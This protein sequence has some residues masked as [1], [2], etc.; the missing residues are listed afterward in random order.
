[1]ADYGATAGLPVD[2]PAFVGQVRDWLDGIAQATDEAFPD[3]KLVRIENDEP[4]ITRPPKRP[5][6]AG[7]RD[8]EARLA[9]H[10]PEENI[11]DMLTDTEHW[12]HWTSPIGPISGH[13]TKLE[14]AVVRYLATV[15]CYG[16]NMGPSQAARSLARLDRRQIERINQHHVIEDGLDQ[17]D[18]IVINAYNRFVLP[19]AWGSGKHA[20]ADGTKWDLYER[21][22]LAEYHIRYGEFGGIGYYHLSDLYIALISHFIPCGAYEGV[23]ILDPF[24]QNKSDIQPDTVHADTHG[25]SAPIFGLAYTL[26]IR[27]MP[28]IRNWK[29]LTLYRPS[30][31]ARYEHIDTLFSANVDW[32]LIATHL[33]DMLRVGISIAAGRITPSTILRKLG[34]YSRKNRLYQAFRELGV[35]VRTGFLLQYIGDAELRSTIQAA[36]NKSESFNDFVQWLAFGGAGVIAENDRA[37]QRKVIKYNHLLANCLIFHN[38]CMMTRVLHRLRAEGLPVEADTVAALSPFI[39][40]HIK[41]VRGVQA[42]PEPRACGDRLRSADPRSD[43][44]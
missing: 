37:E 23:Y 41:Q 21:N 36:T 44:H 6:S 14:D 12:L 35:A 19:R 16:T 27:L 31:E 20:S 5:E 11:L 3:N 8:L 17:A 7:V 33:P 1:V 43:R 18:T 10:M 30:K 32:D 38:V 2:G 15:F 42:R 29:H 34:T 24:Y 4:I 26:G 22:L 39:R 25:Q 9:E 28:R 13:E 40:A